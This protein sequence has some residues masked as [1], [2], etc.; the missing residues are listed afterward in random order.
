M[1]VDPFSAIAGRYSRFSRVW[2]FM[3]PVLFLAACGGSAWFGRANR[4]PVADA[5]PDRTVYQG[6]AVRLDGSSSYDP[7]GP[8]ASYRWVQTAG[9]PV[10]G[11]DPTA[12]SPE[13]VVP[14]VKP[15]GE[16]LQFALTVTDEGGLSHT[17]TVTLDV[18]KYL[19]FDDFRTDTT[20]A[21]ARRHV[22]SGANTGEFFHVGALRNV[23]VIPGHETGLAFSR[24]VPPC[25]HA[26]FSFVFSASRFRRQGGKIRVRLMEDDQT[27]YEIFSSSGAKAGGARKVINGREVDSAAFDGGYAQNIKYPVHIVFGPGSTLVDAFDQLVFMNR[28]RSSIMVKRFDI[29]TEGQETYFDDLVL[30]QDPF[31]RVRILHRIGLW[32]SKLFVAAIPG[33]MPGGSN[34]RFVL[35]GDTENP[36][37]IDVADPPF[38]AM[39]HDVSLSPHTVDAYVLEESGMEALAHDRVTYVGR[40]GY[41]VAIGD[42]ITGGSG[43]LSPLDH[44][45][46]FSTMTVRRAG[47]GPILKNLL[48]SSKGYPHVVVNA[49]IGGHTSGDGLSVLPSLLKIHT[50]ANYFLVLYGTNDAALSIPSGK[51]LS[52]GYKGFDRSFKSN[53]QQIISLIVAAGKTPLLAKVPIVAGAGYRGRRSRRANPHHLPQNVLIR[54]YNAVIDELIRENGI[55]VPAPDFYAHFRA[56]P[57]E[58]SDSVHPNAKGYRSMARLWFGALSR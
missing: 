17:D 39:F 16:R 29:H 55:P 11:L 14:F 1:I 44:A 9:K 4:P 38:E 33:N 31:L 24:D 6:Q 8:I 52:P 45:S 46:S 51:G 53:M 26:T 3:A 54:E 56:N 28:D 42:S 57:T 50:E 12:A 30:T 22:G 27:Y 13:I 10:R 40:D 23:R 19:F 15:P 58:L 20:R 2:T 21:Y 37:V 18:V 35:D 36:V 47:Y 7:D 48:E 25:D 5:G 41:Y 43:D 49:G 32:D 34:V